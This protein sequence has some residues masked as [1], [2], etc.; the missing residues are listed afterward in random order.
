MDEFM[1]MLLEKA[2]KEGKVHV[3]QM[4]EEPKCKCTG[5]SEP[6]NDFFA[7]AKKEAAEIAQLNR[8]LY[9]A[10]IEAGF[11]SEEALAL[12]VAQNN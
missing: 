11:T 8:I 9:E 3:V 4:G 6:K 12:V 10:H 1:K 7:S 2:I 5:E